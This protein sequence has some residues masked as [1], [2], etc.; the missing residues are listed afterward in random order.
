MVPKLSVEQ[1]KYVTYNGFCSPTGVNCGVPQ[2]SMLCPLLFYIYIYIN[3]V[4]TKSQLVVI[5]DDTNLLLKAKDLDILQAAVNKELAD[6]A[7]WFKVNKL[8]QK[9]K[10]T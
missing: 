4:S 9:I 7:K 3:H 8:F 1:I 2:G 10:K 5:A 6:I